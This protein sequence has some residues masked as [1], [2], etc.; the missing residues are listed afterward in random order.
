MGKASTGDMGAN[1]I[2]TSAPR[3]TKIFSDVSVAT[4]AVYHDPTAHLEDNGVLV[5]GVQRRI[6]SRLGQLLGDAERFYD[7]G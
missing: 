6:E 1:A 3:K 4:R 2:H 5:I 7:N